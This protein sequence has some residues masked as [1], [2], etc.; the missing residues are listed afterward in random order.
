MRYWEE[1]LFRQIKI[2]LTV[3]LSISLNKLPWSTFRSRTPKTQISLQNASSGTKSKG[4]IWNRRSNE[5]AFPRRRGELK[6]LFFNSWKR[7]LKSRIISIYKSFLE[8]LL[9]NFGMY[10]RC[11]LMTIFNDRRQVCKYIHSI[12]LLNFESYIIG[13]YKQNK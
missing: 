13:R 4:E 5:K 12:S 6:L 10:L 7:L 3:L 2:L 11:L 1:N 9:H 8:T